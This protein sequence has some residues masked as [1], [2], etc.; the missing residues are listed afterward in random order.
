MKHII[1]ITSLLLSVAASAQSI[2][3]Q[4]VASNGGSSTQLDWTVG[5]VIIYSYDQS[6]GILTQ[7]FQQGTLGVSQVAEPIVSS[8]DIAVYPN[9]FMDALTISCPV[10]FTGDMQWTL[11]DMSGKIVESNVLRN[12]REEYRFEH[13]PSGVYILRVEVSQSEYRTFRIVKQ[14]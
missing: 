10:G 3:R 11:S 7:G 5:E 9:P 14:N 4:V 8:I 2:E 1:A 12:E 13:L 6:A